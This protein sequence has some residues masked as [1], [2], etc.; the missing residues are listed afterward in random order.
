MH[1]IR[2]GALVVSLFVAWACGSSQDGSSQDQRVYAGAGGGFIVQ[3]TGGTSATGVGGQ[4]TNG[5][6]TTP[7][8]LNNTSIGGQSG[9]D[10]QPS[11]MS[12]HVYPSYISARHSR[13]ACSAPL[14]S[15]YYD[16]CFNG[17]SNCALFG[18][19]GTYAECG[20][21]LAATPVTGSTAYGP[22][23]TYGT[24]TAWMYD[25]NLAGCI[26]LW[27]EPTCAANYQRA[28]LCAIDACVNNCPVTDQRSLE[29]LQSCT[30]SA[31]V[32]VCAGL[33]QATNCIA[34]SATATACSGADFRTQF[35]S[36]GYAFCVN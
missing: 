19:G 2:W 8:N 13:A 31:R 21:C 3:S 24:S 32:T 1:Q 25:L 17:G 16:E 15:Q 12:G 14:V 9:S 29:A 33:Q 23:L 35:L 7:T 28:Q 36:F 27:G 22:V 26:E 18:P 20:T 30:N 6:T 34:Q 5:A 4:L 10:C 11:D